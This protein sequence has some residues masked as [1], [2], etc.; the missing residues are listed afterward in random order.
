[1]NPDQAPP[2]GL[3]AR[4]AAH[5]GT[6][7]YG[8]DDPLV[9]GVR[10]GGAPPVF[11]A[12]GRAATGEPL[13]AGTVVYAASLSKQITAACAALLVRRG[14]LDLDSALTR[15]LPELPAWTGS[16]RVR[17]LVSHTSG[18]PEGVE[19]DELHR[20]GLDLTTAAVLD[21][22][23]RFDGLAC[24]PG[25]EHRYSNTGYVCLAVVVERAAGR[26][27]ADFAREHVFGPLGMTATRY[28]SGPAPHPP[29]AAPLDARYPAPLS[30]GD[31]GVWSTAVDLVRWNQALEGDELG[32]SAFLQTPGRLDDGTPLDYAWGLGVR[33]YAGRPVYQHGGRW[34]GLC[35][36]LVRLAGRRSGFVILALDDDEDRMTA[37]TTAVIKELAA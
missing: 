7:G 14:L 11:L 2:A 22:L 3:R 10:H 4:I 12:Q 23:A 16:V 37:L 30:L 32:V 28:W 13:A 34:A 19:F 5:A 35:A 18:L 15:W 26:P 1:M 33:E 20:A 36:Q 25:T 6:A 8:A 27:L 21:G 9:V 24:P 31:G 17:H 29:G